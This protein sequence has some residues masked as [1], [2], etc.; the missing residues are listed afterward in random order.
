MASELCGQ[1]QLDGEVS[2]V[3]ELVIWTEQNRVHTH[4]H[5]RD[6]KVRNSGECFLAEHEEVEVGNV[7]E[8]K[9]LEVVFPVA[10]DEVDQTVVVLEHLDGGVHT[11]TVLDVLERN[12]VG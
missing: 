5:L 9:E 8:V 1:A 7:T 6:S 2:E 11:H 12:H 10:V 3:L 4:N